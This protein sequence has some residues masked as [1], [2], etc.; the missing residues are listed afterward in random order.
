MQ[1]SS[2]SQPC[3]LSACGTP[4][5]ISGQRRCLE[6]PKAQVNQALP[7]YGVVG[8]QLAAV[9]VLAILV[10]ARRAMGVDPMQALRA[11]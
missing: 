5:P 6:R 11:E 1:P 2:R 8:A 7:S 4:D 10:P 3:A 9:A